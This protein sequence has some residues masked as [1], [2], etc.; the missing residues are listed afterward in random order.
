M[1]GVVF[2]TSVRHSPAAQGGCRRGLLGCFPSSLCLPHSGAGPGASAGHPG[3]GRYGGGGGGLA[4]CMLGPVPA[5]LPS[6]LGGGVLLSLAW[7][8]YFSM[9]EGPGEAS[10]VSSSAGRG[11][12]GG[13]GSRSRSVYSPAVVARQS[14]RLTQSRTLLDGR[15]PTIQEKA[16]LRAA[17][18]DIS[19]GT[20]TLPPVS[21][22]S[23]SRFAVLGSVPLARLAEVA[24]DCDNVFRGE[25]RGPRLEQISAIGTKERFDGALAEARSL[26]ER[27]NP[28]VPSSSNP[29]HREVRVGPEVVGNLAGVVSPDA[30]H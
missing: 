23:D 18:R 4:E 12:G 6:L 21:S 28:T 7:I 29:G 13:D 3:P 19:P 16:A 5:V 25:R 27:G 11:V 17:A 22:C 8:P 14:A 15:V 24:S 30:L 1:E 9:F 2:R 10:G 20:S 26:V